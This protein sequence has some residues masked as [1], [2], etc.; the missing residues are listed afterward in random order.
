[1]HGIVFSE[2]QKFVVSQHGHPG[3]QKLVDKASLGHKV[4]LAA[5]QYPDSEVVALVTA[6]SAM[7]G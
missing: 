4:Y 7:T 6:A 5:G 2:L 3:W 1:M